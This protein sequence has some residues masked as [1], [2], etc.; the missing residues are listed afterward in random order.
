VVKTAVSRLKSLSE[1]FQAMPCPIDGL[2]VQVDSH[3]RPFRTGCFENCFR[4]TSSSEGAVQV[5]SPGLGPER[6][7]DFSQEHW[8]MQPILLKY[9]IFLTAKHSLASGAL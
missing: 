9:L 3:D 8:D 6:L 5:N 1:P 4:V 7:N 2:T